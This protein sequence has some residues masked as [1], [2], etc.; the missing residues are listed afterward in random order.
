MPIRVANG[1]FCLIT[2]KLCAVTVGSSDKSPKTNRKLVFRTVQMRLKWV[3]CTRRKPYKTAD[4]YLIERSEAV[5]DRRVKIGGTARS[6]LQ[7]HLT[8]SKS[9][10]Q[11]VVVLI[12]K[13]LPLHLLLLIRSEL[14]LM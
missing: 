8:L 7:D 9:Q 14:G 11:I 12:N 10:Q 6:A 13:F 1:A 2:E 5:P 4:M 3:V